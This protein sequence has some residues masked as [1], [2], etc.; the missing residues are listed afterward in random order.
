MRYST[1]FILLVLSLTYE[2]KAQDKILLMNGQELNVHVLGQ[3]TLGIRYEFLK[4]N[5]KLKSFEEATTSVFS[6]TDSLGKE[7]IWY[8]YDPEFGNDLTV[9]DMRSFILGEQ[10][11][12]LGY[13]P[14]LTTI[15]G[16]VFGAGATIALEL[17]I[18][19]FTLPPIYAGVMSIPRVHVTPGSVNDPLMDG[20][21]NYA[22]GYAQVGRSKRLIRGLI[23]TFAGI[24]VGLGVNEIRRNN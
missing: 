3:S 8:F 15:G 5:G 22:Y 6:V 1:L 18:L 9:P 13:N 23:S 11:A 16:F 7:R 10:D 12:R 20:D 21:P 17:E 4:K 24:A 2:L 19:A 14:T